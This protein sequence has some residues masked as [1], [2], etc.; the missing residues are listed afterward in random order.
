MILYHVLAI[1]L[2]Y[3]ID[4]IVGDPKS[5]PHPVKWMGAFIATFDQRWN[6][7]KYRKLK[8]LCM[9]ISLLILVIGLSTITTILFYQWHVLAG[10]SF[11]AVLIASTISQKSLKAAAMEVIHPLQDQN[12]VEARNNL[13]YI[14]GRDTD[15][16]PE[17]EIVRGTIETV[18]ENT[19]DG[20]TAPLF[21]A[22]IGGAPLALAY[23]AVNTCDSLVGYRNKQYQDFGWAS[24]RLDDL[25]NWVPARL[26]AC[27]MMMSMKPKGI[28]FKQALSILFRDAK[29]H[30]SPNSGWGETAV[31]AILGIQLGG[32]NVYHGKQSISPLLGDPRYPLQR[33]HILQTIAIMQRTVFFF[34][35]FLIIGCI[36]YELASI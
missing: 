23:R 5:W 32:M 18:A 26:T 4:L 34:V 25:L 9:L 11:E 16:L 7:G 22:M 28:T 2:A 31:A 36:V 17:Q 29:K 6:K 20:I 13:S 24:A 12:L 14:V 3:L 33:H 19:S 15:Q 10:I 27:F 21:W 35:L 8:G 30:H 1:I